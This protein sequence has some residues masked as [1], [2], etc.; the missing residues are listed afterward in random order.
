ML[1]QFLLVLLFAVSGCVT[2]QHE[3]GQLGT[4]DVKLDIIKTIELENQS[5]PLPKSVEQATE[6]LAH[7]LSQSLE[8]DRSVTLT[9]LSETF[10]SFTHNIERRRI[11]GF[12]ILSI[13][14]I[15]LSSGSAIIAQYWRRT[16]CW[17]QHF[18]AWE[19]QRTLPI[20][21]NTLAIILSK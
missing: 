21:K 6:E 11:F 17:L 15:K 10:R 5:D 7:E 8:P 1:W 18:R 2:Q 20:L 19:A 16:A 12:L 14:Y 9:S 13:S 3:F 4:P